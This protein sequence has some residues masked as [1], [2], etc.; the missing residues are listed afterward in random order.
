MQKIIRS[1]VTGYSRVF[2]V[3][4]YEFELKIQNLNMTDQNRHKL[5]ESPCKRLSESSFG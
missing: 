5:L 3:A 2:V 4:D 1:G